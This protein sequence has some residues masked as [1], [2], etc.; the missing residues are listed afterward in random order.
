MG[1]EI[2]TFCYIGDHKLDG[3]SRLKLPQQVV[4]AIKTSN[5]RNLAGGDFESKNDWPSVEVAYRDSPVLVAINDAPSSEPFSI[6]DLVF[7]S[8]G[9]LEGRNPV[10]NTED[11]DLVFL[12]SMTDA[13]MI[14]YQDQPRAW[15]KK[16]GSSQ[17]RKDSR[18]DRFRLAR[19]DRQHRIQLRPFEVTIAE[20]PERYTRVEGYQPLSC[21]TLRKSDYRARG[22]NH[23]RE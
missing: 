4:T 18:H 14:I 13:M 21:F 22:G 10:F 8:T 7:V 23:T 16:Q 19:I 6:D 20:G 17:H 11:A 9:V 3:S 12:Y 15:R 5:H 2:S 1:C